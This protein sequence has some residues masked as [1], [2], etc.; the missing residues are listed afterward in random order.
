M[1]QKR[2]ACKQFVPIQ[3]VLDQLMKSYACQSQQDLRRIWQCWEEA[4][5]K[6][7]SQNTR[8]AALRGKRLIVNVASP[9]WLHQLQFL[10]DD[11]IDNLNRHAGK[12]LVEDIRFRIGRL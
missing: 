12:D 4:V 11:L 7:V 9:T 2:K 8:P 1:A 5:G 3:R 10:K 6:A